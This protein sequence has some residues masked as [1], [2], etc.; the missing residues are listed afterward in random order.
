MQETILITGGAG[1]VGSQ[2]TKMLLNK[3]YKVIHVSRSVLGKAVVPTFQWDLANKLW[4]SEAIKEVDYI[5]HLAGA[6]VAEGRWT[7]Q[8]KQQI[9][10]TRID[11]SKLVAQMVNA[12]KGKIKGVVSASAVGYYGIINKDKPTI[13]T[14]EPGADFLAGVCVKWEQ[15]ILKCA[16]K[17]SI[18]RTGVVL[19][20][21]GGAIP[22][23]LTPIKLGGGASLGTGNQPMPWIH[24]NDLCNMYLFAIQNRLEG[25][26]NAV[27]PAPVSNKELTI[28]LAKAVNRKILLP[29]IP[30]FVLKLML[31][32]MASMLLTGVEVSADKIK[33]EG[34]EFNYVSLASSLNNL[35]K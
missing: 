28:Q 18:L 33:K 32:E 34:F 22:K 15:E 12:S 31:G 27:A 23:M 21:E 7:A 29:N 6:N 13:E 2:L 4:D 35:L 5:I 25:V 20:K 16:T 19:A 17:V 24:I 3:D 8:R 26:Y 30:G 11:G 14:D 9:L 10:E 1:L